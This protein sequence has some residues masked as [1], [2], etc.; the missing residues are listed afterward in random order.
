M[1]KVT[2][3]L[4]VRVPKWRIW[5]MRLIIPVIA[6]FIRGDDGLERISSAMAKFVGRGMRVYAEDK[7]VD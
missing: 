4:K 6:P 1:A 7:R 3:N 5:I 2:L